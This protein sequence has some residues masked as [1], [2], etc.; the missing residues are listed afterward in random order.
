MDG[1]DNPYICEELMITDNT[2]KKHVLNIYRKLGVNNRVG[3]FKMIK[4]QE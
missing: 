4:E 2:L 1:K 3:L